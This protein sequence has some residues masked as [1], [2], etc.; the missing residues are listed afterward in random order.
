MGYKKRKKEKLRRQG[1]VSLH[2]LR[3]RRHRANVTLAQK[4]RQS[5]PPRSYK[6]KTLMGIWRVIGRFTIQPSGYWKHPAP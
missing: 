5:P 6:K 3:K 2:Q 4:S 1:K